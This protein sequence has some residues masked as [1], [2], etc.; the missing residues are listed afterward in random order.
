MY[1]IGNNIL[2]LNNKLFYGSAAIPFPS[3]GLTY[4]WSFNEASGTAVADSVAAFNMTLNNASGRVSGGKN[5]NAFQSTSSQYYATTG[6]WTRWSTTQKYTISYWIKMNTADNLVTA[7]L[8]NID[9]S[10]RC[11]IDIYHWDIAHANNGL[12]QFFVANGSARCWVNKAAF[13]TD[14]NWHNVVCQYNGDR[15]PSNMKVWLDGQAVTLNIQQ[16]NLNSDATL[17]NTAIQ[18]GR[19]NT[20]AYTTNSIIDEVAVWNR[21]ITPAEVTLLYNNG[22]GLFY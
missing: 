11:I 7:V 21:F 5:G 22:N 18:I 20:T 13:I 2:R 15:N 19:R 17:G 10:T 14:S 16:N 4:Y 12:L 3:S 8:S 9:G 1:K 6:T